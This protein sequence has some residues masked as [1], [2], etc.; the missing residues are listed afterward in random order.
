VLPQRPDCV[1][2]HVRLELR[3]V[4]AK[5]PF[6]RSHRFPVI[7]P[8]SGRR[9]CSRLSCGVAERQLGLVPGHSCA[10]AGRS[11]RWQELPRFCLR[12]S[13][14]HG[15]VR[16]EATEASGGWDGS[17]ATDDRIGGGF[18]SADKQDSLASDLRRLAMLE[19]EAQHLSRG[20][21]ALRIGV[22]ASGAASRPSMSGS[23]DVPVFKDCPPARVGM[24]SARI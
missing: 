18:P 7:Q 22:G 11:L 14:Y 5:Y 8:N 2:G 21:R 24:D 20:V 15:R 16:R 6:E 1:A 9:D 12:A 13:Y 10:N 3:N 17:Q 19:E 23:M 4:V